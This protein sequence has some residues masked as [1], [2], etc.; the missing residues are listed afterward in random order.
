VFFIKN[1]LIKNSKFGIL[2]EGLPIII[3]YSK[4]QLQTYEALKLQSC[5]K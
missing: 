2:Y 4:S 5:A 1:V 3:P